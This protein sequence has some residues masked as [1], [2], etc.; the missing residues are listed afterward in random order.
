[1]QPWDN[2]C[3]ASLVPDFDKG[4]VRAQA[5]QPRVVGWLTCADCGAGPAVCRVAAG[6]SDREHDRV[7]PAAARERN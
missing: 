2:E 3:S 5:G 1:M 7:V 4:E 6:I